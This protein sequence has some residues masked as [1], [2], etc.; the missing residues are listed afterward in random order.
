MGQRRILV[1][2]SQCDALGKLDFLPELAVQLYNAFTNPDIGMCESALEEQ[3]GLLI[4]RQATDIKTA[5]K[6]AFAEAS[7]KQDTLILALIGHGVS[8]GNDDFYYMTKNSPKEPDSDNAVQLVQLIKESYRR[9]SFIDG[10]IVL[11]DTCYSG[12]AAMGAAQ[13]WA[14]KLM[15]P[16]RFEI[17]TATG[18]E[19]AYDGCFTR[20]LIDTLLHGLPAEQSETLRCFHLSEVVDQDQA[21][22]R[23]QKSDH[24]ARKPDPGLFLAK[25]VALTARQRPWGRSGMWSEI[26]RHTHWF[27]PTPQLRTIVKMSNNKRCVAL[28]GKAGSGKSALMASLARPEVTGGMIPE[29][30]LQAIVFL[31]E[32]TDSAT[33]A[34]ELSQ[35]L[36]SSVEGFADALH[37]YQASIPLEEWN[38]IEIMQRSVLAPLRKLPPNQVVRIGVD[39]LDQ[40]PESAVLGVCRALNSLT[41]DEDLANVRL[42]VSSR[43]DTELSAGTGIL[44]LDAAIESDLIAYLARRDVSTPYQQSIIERA[45][46]SWLIARLLADLAAEG[47]LKPEEL[48]GKLVEIYERILLSAGATKRN[49]RWREQLRP[50]LSVLAVS[51][52]GP[53]LP[54]AFL[55]DAS[56]RLGG[57]SKM[58]QI[59]DLLVDLRGFVDR[60]F[61]GTENECDGLFHSTFSEYLLDAGKSRFSS[62][63]QEA[64]SALVAAI[65]ALAPMEQHNPDSLLHQYAAT[66]E[67]PLLWT[68][69][70]QDQA[71]ESLVQRDSIIPREN[72]THW[73][74]WYHFVKDQ[75]P[76]DDQVLLT[77]RNNIAGFTGQS[78]DVSRGLELC[79]Q[80]LPDQERVLGKDHPQ[81][82]TNRNNIAG[83]TG[84]SG[85]VRRGLE[86]YQQLLPDQE[87]VLGKDHPE[88]LRT[89]NN[90]A[91]FTGQSGD[92]RR[93]L[94]L[95]Q[96]LLPDQERVLGKNHPQPLTTLAN[97]AS[98]TGQSGDMRRGLELCQQLLPNQ[99]RVLGKNHPQTLTTRNN[100]AGF[101]GQSGDMRRGLELYQQLLPDQER[102]LGKDHPETLTTRN[103]IAGFT[104]QSGDV[105]RGLE[106][107]QQL[108]PDQERV[109]GKDHPQT[110]Q[111]LAN[112]AGFT[113]RSGDVRRGLE[114]C[115]QL[116]PDQERVLGKDHPQTLTTRNNIA[117]FTGQSGDVSRG[118]ELCQQLL[119][120]QERVLGKD[121]PQTL[122]TRNDIALF[123]GQSG[124]V[125]RGLELCQQLLPDQERVLGKDHPQILT[126][127]NNIAGFT[128]QSGDMRRGLELYQQLL[129]DQER[130]LGKNHPETLTTLANIAGF[131]G[132]SGDVRRGLELYQQLLPNQERV[133]G[134]DHP[135][136]LTT[137][138]NIALFTGQSGD[139]RR[140]LELCQQLLPDQERVRGKDHPETLTTRN[141]IAGF[142]VHSG[143]VRRGLELCQQLLPDQERVLGKDHPQTLLVRE[144]IDSL[145]SALE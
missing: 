109:L 78:G 32:A 30:F 143:D 125:S 26:E 76:T 111:T 135:Q 10:L 69:G 54:I 14:A 34:N 115:Q 117:L 39:A 68:L 138:N 99:E 137:R 62:E 28:I 139:V 80:L 126:T 123:T 95:C 107:C 124:D 53:I 3:K 119:P 38:K 131:T 16:T 97:I 36:Q 83:F 33:L 27:Q 86:L 96:Q 140:G 122:T 41:Q 75:L 144:W 94:E 46:G 116:L 12:V 88:T 129:H 43:P 6:S 4:D 22:G 20:I 128:G 45:A 100:I 18:R 127:R 42:L 104:G 11:V 31:T 114:L 2:G 87:R 25:N 101:T 121:H 60:R 65:A 72:L 85:D 112:I 47:K 5:I 77:T 56:Q 35:Q 48:P 23:K 1:I 49:A 136:T 84:Q 59:R 21:C 50:V 71:L 55:C 133:L 44:P 103:N 37:D 40:I 108:L 105:R 113:G 145:K 8:V 13:D 61:P 142:T 110:L 130:V 57:L 141:N 89:R 52:A 92:V 73:S 132:Q 66:V 51:G 90:I 24:I 102:V 98:F 82:L 81:I 70:R 74:S 7:K 63:R 79:Q 19:V 93:G 9:Y 106:L 91:G 17:L 134:K 67:A 58:S 118:L 120:D 29:R 15:F 64:Q